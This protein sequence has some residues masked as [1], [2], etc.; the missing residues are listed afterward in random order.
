MWGMS[1]SS[2][3]KRERNGSLT[4]LYEPLKCQGLLRGIMNDYWRGYTMEELC[5][6]LTVLLHMYRVYVHV[7]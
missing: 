1:Y 2:P 4:D 7:V 5:F 6:S 3:M